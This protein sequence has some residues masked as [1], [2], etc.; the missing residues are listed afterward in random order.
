MGQDVRIWL[1]GLNASHAVPTAVT[2]SA[3]AR[4]EDKGAAGAASPGAPSAATGAAAATAVAA[5]TR[6]IPGSPGGL[7]LRAS[8]A[9]RALRFQKA[10][11]DAG[12]GAPQTEGLLQVRALLQRL[13]AAPTS[14]L[15][16]LLAIMGASSGSTASAGLSPAAGGA[17]PGGVSV[18]E[19][20]N[21]G[22][23]DGGQGETTWLFSL[24]SPEALRL[25]TLVPLVF[26]GCLRSMTRHCSCPP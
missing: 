24:P 1:L 12:C 3:S 13:P 4:G 18:F 21:S 23:E 22:E 2:R 19:L 7:T 9:A 10:H 11:Y 5:A 14:T 17:P 6:A 25:F 16:D 26:V 15:T 20:L 8:L